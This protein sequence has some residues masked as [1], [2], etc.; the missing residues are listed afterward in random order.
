MRYLTQTLSFLGAFLLLNQSVNADPWFTGPLL[1]PA[2]H[3]VAKGHTNFEIYGLDVLN[4]GHYDNN[5]HLIHTNLFKSR[6]VNPIITHGFTEWLDVQLAVPYAFNSTQNASYNRLADISVALGLQLIEQN[7]S[8]KRVDLRVLVQETFPTGRYE[9][10][11]AKR[12]GTDS[13]GLG[14]YQTQVGLNLQYLLQVFDTHY[15]RTR[16]IFSHLFTTPV[17]VHGLDSYGGTK[18]TAGTINAGS[19]NTFDIAFEYTLT[20]NWVAVMEGTIAN[21]DATRFNGVLNTGPIGQPTTSSIGSGD[22]K[23]KALAPAV[24]YNFNSNLGLIG[25]V[26]FPVSGKNTSHYTTYVLALNAYW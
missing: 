22:Y 2:G 5:E 8:P 24:E 13:T 4:N 25:G 6:I 17:K 12:L 10:L 19:D 16:L 14:S 1:A 21:G 15:L 20:Q 3:T 7:K 9:R 26:W 23:E 18:T 11:S